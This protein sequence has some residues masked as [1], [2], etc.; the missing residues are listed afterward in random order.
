MWQRDR[1]RKRECFDTNF[2]GLLYWLFL[3]PCCDFIFRASLIISSASWPGTHCTPRW[4]VP[5]RLLPWLGWDSKWLTVTDCG[6]LCIYNFIMPT[7]PFW[8]MIHLICLH[9]HIACFP[10]ITLF[11]QV[12]PVLKSLIDVSCKS[13]YATLSSVY[14]LTLLLCK[15]LHSLILCLFVTSL[16]PHNLHLPFCCVLSLFALI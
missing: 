6:Y 10:V 11:T 5:T 13:Q 9:P 1:D 15:L 14:S 2:G 12:H 7:L 16:S 4:V 3:N 8:F